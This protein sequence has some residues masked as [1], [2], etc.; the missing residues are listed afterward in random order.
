M[1]PTVT[2]H[3]SHVMTLPDGRDL[4]WLELGAPDGWPV[5]GFHGTPGS[6]LQLA[7]NEP[8]IRRA[9]VRMIA[10]D[11]PG[12]GFST[13]HTDRRL[14]DWPLDVSHLADHLG[15]SRFSVMGVSGG[16]PHAA[17]CAALLA[18]SVSAAGIVSGVGPLSNPRIAADSTL[19]SKALTSLFRRRSAVLGA[20]FVVQ[21]AFVRRWPSTALDLLAK[22][23]PEADAE[24]LRRPEVRALFE[25]DVVRASRT[26]ARA[27]G[28][29]LALFASDWGFDLGSIE[30]PV[31]LW[32]GDADRNVPVRHAHVLHEAIHT[33]VLRTFEGEGHLLVVDRLEE[34]L[35]VLTP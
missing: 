20:F 10:P 21:A 29:D 9:G 24:V 28:Q 25:L 30:V 34:I 11:R 4:G 26:A 13:Y 35:H 22:Q 8:A 7:L 15:I 1:T 19:A 18:R 2:E 23:L 17:A 32:Q 14:V 5:F 31:F 27:Q 12:Y 16:G 6:R 33:S 3:D